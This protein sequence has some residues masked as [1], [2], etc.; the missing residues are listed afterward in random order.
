MCGAQSE[1]PHCSCGDFG[2]YLCDYPVGNDKTCDAPM[3]DQH[4]RSVAPEIDYCAAHYAEWEAYRNTGA[5][6]K[7]LETVIPFRAEKHP[8]KSR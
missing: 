8:A 3:C 5:V 2:D 6:L 4:R 1:E 7:H